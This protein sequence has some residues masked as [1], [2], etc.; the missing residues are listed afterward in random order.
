MHP[1]SPPPPRLRSHPPTPALLLPASPPPLRRQLLSPL[2][3]PRPLLPAT[4]IGPPPQ[5]PS[6]IITATT[7]PQITQ[8]APIPV[9]ALT[10]TAITYYLHRSP[11]RRRFHHHGGYRAIV[12]ADSLPPST[13]SDRWSSGAGVLLHPLFSLTTA[14]PTPDHIAFAR[15]PTQPFTSNQT[16]FAPLPTGPA[17]GDAVERETLTGCGED[18][19]CR[20]AY[21][22]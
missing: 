9:S 21:A 17:S 11:H 12:A 22:L 8:L 4:A 13:W 20:K 3:P 14:P 19:R 16:C 1:P 18:T 2:P 10:A 7:S 6:A 15:A 5:S